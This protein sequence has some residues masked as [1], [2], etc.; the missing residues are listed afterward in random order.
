V[1]AVLMQRDEK[2]VLHPVAFFSKT[3][4]EAQQNYDVYNKELLGLIEMFR[5]WWQYLHQATHTVKVHTDHANLLYW[6]NP[7]DHNRRVAR[8]HAELMDYDFQLVHISGKKNGRVDALSRRADHDEGENDNKGLV[9]L[10]PKVFQGKSHARLAGSG[11]FNPA[12]RGEL[13]KY[14]DGYDLDYYYPVE[15]MVK[16]DQNTPESIK[17]IQGWTNTHQLIR[18]NATWWKD[19]WIIVARDNNLKRGVIHF[20][21]DTPSTGHPGISNTY[22]I[23]K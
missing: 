14:C 20:F 18:E 7:G 3:M 17:K 12:K 1:G 6:K 11:F 19:D 8:W 9:V 16:K 21:H 23:A 15:E 5:H 10:P 2:N 22:Q 4:N 13:E